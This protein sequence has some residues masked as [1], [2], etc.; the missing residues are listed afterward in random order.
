ML[1]S[2]YYHGT[3]RKYV[4]LFGTL[5][6]EIYINRTDDVHNVTNSIKI[7]LMYA[8]R[9]KVLARLESDPN[10]QKPVATVLPRMAFEITTMTYAPTR[11]LQTIGK[12]RKVDPAN[13]NT[14]KYNYNPVPYDISFS[15]YIM[16]KNQDDG[17]QIL[18][19][20]LPYFTPEWT[21]T[22][23][24]IPEM[25]IVQDIP[26]VLLNVTPQDTYEGS[27][28]ERRVITWTLDFIMKGYFY[29]PTRKSGIITLANTN[30]YDASLYD[31]IDTAVGH[32]P[33]VDG[34]DVEPGQTANGQ[35][36]SNAS[37]TVDRNEITANSQY[38]YIV[39][40]G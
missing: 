30:F 12:N 10:L 5:F 39:K 29:G 31:D 1:G 17:T 40:L 35:P 27:F 18:E 26:L 6:N 15:L 28:E 11:K 23:N 13:P 36:T 2:T 37:L 9:E 21:T 16:V 19:Q 8:P 33:R 3:L 24:L 4:T 14:L 34:S 7:P 25:N 32:A 20:I 38:G 22:I